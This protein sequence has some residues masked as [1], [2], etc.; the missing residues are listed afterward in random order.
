M[1]SLAQGATSRLP[2]Q[3]RLSEILI[4]T[5]QPYDATQVNE[6]KK[7]AEELRKAIREGRA[8]A[9]LARTDSQGPTAAQGGDLGYFTRG[10]LAR[11]M[12]DLV[13]IMKAGDVSDVVRTK[14][15]FVIL[16]VTDHLWPG[17]APEPEQLECKEYA[18]PSA[19]FA[20]TLPFDPKPHDDPTNPGYT[21]YTVHLSPTLVVTFRSTNRQDCVT[22]LNDARDAARRKA[23]PTLV[24]G[25]FKEV[26]VQGYPGQEWQ[27]AV[28]AVGY[29]QYVRQ[30]CVE[31]RFYQFESRWP[32]GQQMPQSVKRILNSLRFLSVSQSH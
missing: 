31:G 3:V 1:D 23:E 5:S 29:A 28:P 15:G 30:V 26:T 19:G 2:E 8:F 17:V 7:K 20:I 27:L 16:Q 4:R 18:Y 6:A 14:Q 24:N 12:E 32:V 25:S 11:S 22:I 10:K 9:D 21:V 13:F